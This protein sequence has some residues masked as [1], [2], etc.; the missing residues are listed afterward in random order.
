[1]GCVFRFGGLQSAIGQVM[2]FYC[3]LV[4]SEELVV[5]NQVVGEHDAVEMVCFVFDGLC[6]G[7]LGFQFMWLAG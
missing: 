2:W 4:D 1:M 6:K 7:T 3:V 5:G